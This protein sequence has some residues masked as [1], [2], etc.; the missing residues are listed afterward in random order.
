MLQLRGQYDLDNSL[1]SKYK[2]IDRNLTG[3]RSSLANRSYLSDIYIESA[4]LPV[5]Y[6]DY[7]FTQKSYV[8]SEQ[9]G[10]DE[11]LINDLARLTEESINKNITYT[12]IFVSIDNLNYDNNL[13][14]SDM[15]VPVSDTIQSLYTKCLTQITAREEGKGAALDDLRLCM[16]KSKVGNHI[17]SI[18]NFSDYLQASDVFL[19]IGLLPVLFPD[20]KE[21]LNE[22]ELEYF[23]ALV[24]RSQIKR[25]SNVVVTELFEKAVQTKKYMDRLDA[26]LFKKVLTNLSE[27]RLRNVRRR[28]DDNMRAAESAMQQYQ[29]ALIALDELHLRM[30]SLED[31]AE[32]FKEEVI[33]VKN[34]EGVESMQIDSA[35]ILLNMSTT[36][37]Y[38]ETDEA[39]IVI[40]R[41]DD[42]FMKWLF[43]KLFIEQ[44]I[45][46]HIVGCL[47]YSLD[48]SRN[49][50]HLYAHP[51]WETFA[52]EQAYY[53]PHLEHFA[54]FGDYRPK[55]IKAQVDG[56][57]LLF[58]N[59]GLASMRA[60]NFKDGTVLGR[61]RNDLISILNGNNFTSLKMFEDEQGNRLTIEQLHTVWEAFENEEAT[62]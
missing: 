43:T 26:I 32:E 14:D 39:E 47:R 27:N 22:E 38:F 1:A 2:Y 41:M 8:L 56:D 19:T 12:R 49:D 45:K 28:I 21:T 3:S 54:C 60:L 13:L 46:L 10:L 58:A 6:N 53:N 30:R 52:K 50:S 4:L 5:V 18:Q 23:K 51:A 7:E 17:V 16:Y 59:I 29:N 33:A 57:L 34:M 61:F 55:L 25:I 48:N 15:F 20:F 35:H 44:S 42:D 24:T 31:G 9:L 40:N 11:D 62:D 37:R 36:L